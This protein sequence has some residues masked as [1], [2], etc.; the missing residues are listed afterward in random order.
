MKIFFKLAS[1]LVSFAILYGVVTFSASELGGEVV[2]LIRPE[3]DE[4]T[5]EVRLRI[6]DVVTNRG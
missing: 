4:S 5:K 2:V 6:V 3:P 1:I